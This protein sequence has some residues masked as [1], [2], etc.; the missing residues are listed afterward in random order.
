MK[1]PVK[2]RGPRREWTEEELAAARRLRGLGACF[3]TVAR[4]LGT[5]RT[6]DAVRIRLAGP[7]QA[8]APAP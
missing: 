1:A 8:R 4:A 3:K 6:G 2:R 5:G 7:E